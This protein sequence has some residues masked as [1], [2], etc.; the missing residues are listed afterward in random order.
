VKTDTKTE[1][2]A[3]YTAPGHSMWVMP[4]QI[5]V[6]IVTNG[7]TARMINFSIDLNSSGPSESNSVS[8]GCSGESSSLY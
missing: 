8:T 7:S 5:I 1:E 6:L 4:V 3:T 2:I